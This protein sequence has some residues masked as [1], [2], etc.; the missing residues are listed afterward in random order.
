MKYR[1]KVAGAV[2]HLKR[3]IRI[4]K[5][6]YNEDTQP[7]LSIF[8]RMINALEEEFPDD[9][10]YNDRYDIRMQLCSGA[11]EGMAVVTITCKKREKSPA[12]VAPME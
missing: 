10:C 3:R 5:H 8:Q 4:M 6:Q 7:E 1:Y 9:E 11:C 12:A 2:S